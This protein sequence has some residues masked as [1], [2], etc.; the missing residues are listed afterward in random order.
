MDVIVE[1]VAGL[2]IGEASVTVCVRVPG[3]GG[4]RASET[5][6]YSTMT[7]HS[8]VMTDCLI[9][10]GVTPAAFGPLLGEI[11]VTATHHRRSHIPTKPAEGLKN[12]SAV[13]L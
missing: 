7:R 11:V 13:G 12:A 3:P 6:A 5:R 2:D 9:E 1:R 10:F 4:R 8:Q